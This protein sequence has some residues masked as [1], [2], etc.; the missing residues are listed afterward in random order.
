MGQWNR[1]QKRWNLFAHELKRIL[2]TRQ[3]DLGQLPDLIGVDAEKI[4]RLQR[5]LYEPRLFPLL[6]EDEMR[7]LAHQL[8]LSDEEI[9]DLHAALLATAVNRM[10]IDRIQQDDA[11]LA[12]EQI[13]PIILGSLQARLRNSLDT[14]RGDSSSIEDTGPDE[15]FST[16][17]EATEDGALALQLSR[18]VSSHRE[19]LTYARQAL[20]HFHEALK[21]LDDVDDELRQLRSWNYWRNRALKG[22]T[23]V[24]QRIDE[25]GG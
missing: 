21:E 6:D 25:L 17:Q 10:L 1:S 2:A 18:R 15:I 20:T 8:Q 7:L 22:R 12:T 5:S 9:T 14:T 24:Q 3:L 19:R 16:A 13:F 23:Q 11:L 4:A